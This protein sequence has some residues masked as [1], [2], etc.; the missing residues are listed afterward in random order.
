L[1]RITSALVK[2]LDRVD[3]EKVQ[4]FTIAVKHFLSGYLDSQKQVISDS[5]RFY[6]LDCC[7][8]GILLFSKTKHSIISKI[9]ILRV[10]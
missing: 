10:D 4:E 8:M 7:A 3:E 2:E 5:A 9:L 1:E 6:D